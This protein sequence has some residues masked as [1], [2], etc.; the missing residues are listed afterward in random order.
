MLRLRREIGARRL[1]K[2]KKVRITSFLEDHNVV[3]TV[4]DTGP[5]VPEALRLKVF[6]PFFTTKESGEGTGLGLSISYGIIK[7]HRGTIEVETPRR[8][9]LFRVTFPAL[10]RENDNGKSTR[11]G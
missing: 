6:E 5:G 8:G 3:V 1:A 10:K 2:P 7:E 9:S 4:S 11:G